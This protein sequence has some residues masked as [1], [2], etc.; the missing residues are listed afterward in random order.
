M[1]KLTE[2]TIHEAGALLRS[3]SV[4]S[5]DLVDA[6]LERIELTE[7]AL[8][9]Y[10]HVMER[11]A[12]ED[13]RQADKELAAGIWR[14][15][16]HGIPIGIKDLFYTRGVP[17]EGGSRVLKGF[18]PSY[19]ATAVR[20]LKDAGAVTLGKTVTNEFAYG[21]NVPPTRN[22]WNRDYY[23]GGSSAGSG[24]A[25]AVGSAF[26]AIGT[27]TGGSI[28]V[29]AAINGL[30]GLKPTLG[31]VS[32]HGVIPLSA[33]MDHVGPMTRDVEDCALMLQA[34]AGFDPLDVASLDRPIPDYSAGLDAGIR[35][36]RLGVDRAYFF[37]EAVVPDVRA[38]VEASLRSLEGLGAEIVD[39]RIPELEL[40]AIVGLTI[41]Q[42]EG[43]TH[44]LPLLRSQS[45]DYE[46]GTRLILILGGLIPSTEYVL[47][48]KARTVIA[49]AVRNTFESERLTALVGPTLPVPTFRLEHMAVDFLGGGAGVDLSGIIKHGVVANVTGLPAL[50][51]AC[52]LSSDGLPIGLQMMGRPFA[53]TSLFQI[54]RAHEAVTTWHTLRPD[55]S[56]L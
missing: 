8:H 52:G 38:A 12:R 2:L 49:A 54:A 21:L 15:P 46:N 25:T 29:P 42:V 50:T 26:G 19:D 16:L 45:P 37:S 48:L 30:V 34:I 20:R 11:S 22:P 43:S 28:R 27:D 3:R 47:S 44:H 9:A 40:A 33:S 35:G 24:V 51:V 31:R 10:A 6:S 17:T 56:A 7:P 4:S 53:E 55:L 41:L 1:T 18:V 36:L 5:S 14:G 39:V 23:P 13:A 32:R